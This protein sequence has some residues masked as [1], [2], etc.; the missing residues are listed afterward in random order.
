MVDKLANIRIVLVETS[1]PGNIGAAAR[2]MKTMGLQDMALVAPKAF[3]HQQAIDLAA[4]ADDILQQAQCYADL[5]S[6]LA[7]CH[8]VFGTS[9]RVR[10]IPLNYV[11][12]EQCAAQAA[13]VAESAGK[14]AI[15]FGRERTG[16]TNDELLHCQQHVVIA[17]NPD[18]ASL[19]L[20][21]AVQI[22]CYTC[23]QALLQEQPPSQEVN[24]L[25]EQADVERFF[26]HLEE[27]LVSLEFLKPENPKRLMTRL[28]RLFSRTEL[29]TQEVAILR[30]ILTAINKR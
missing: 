13:Q 19:N 15:V 9:A 12:P 4:G 28:R 27:T 1:H 25:A 5:P 8:T 18:Y 21:Q 7:D 29:E 16:L 11:S 20:A 23:R 2:A 17:T 24:A 14:V 3:P 22:L 26:A 6:A 30:G 10:H